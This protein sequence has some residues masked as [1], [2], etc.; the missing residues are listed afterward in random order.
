MELEAKV[1]QAKQDES[2]LSELI[3]TYKPFIN[4]SAA[5]VTNHFTDSSSDEASVAMLAFCEAV[6]TF[7]SKKG[8]FLPYAQTVIKSR[9]IDYMRKENPRFQT[10]A[11]E[12]IDNELSENFENPVRIEIEA[13]DASLERYNISF[14]ELADCSPKSHKT[15][16]TMYGRRTIYHDHR[17]VF[18]AIQ[19]KRAAADCRYG[20]SS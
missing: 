12:H 16:K 20:I 2:V 1:Y 15:K 5:A 18:D 8:Y 4:S 19:A 14:L 6:K 17:Y 13:L 10:V 11:L 3:E 9:M 7:D